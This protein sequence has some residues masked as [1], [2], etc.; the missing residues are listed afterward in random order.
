MA[1]APSDEEIASAILKLA[2]ER[3]PK[4]L[5]PSEIARRLVPEEGAWRALMGRVRQVAQTLADN[6][7]V[8]I[9]QRGRDVQ[10]LEARGPIRLSARPS[11][12]AT[13]G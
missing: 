12:S 7:M 9:T 10:A 3:A 1:E 2:A 8:R 11:R 5:C 4:T 13:D 6:G